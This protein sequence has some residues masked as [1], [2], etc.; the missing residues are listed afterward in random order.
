MS[1]DFRRRNI[2]NPRKFSPQKSLSCCYPQKFNCENVLQLYPRKFSP[3]KINP[4]YGMLYC[5]NFNMK[6]RGVYLAKA[7]FDLF[8]PINVLIA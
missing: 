7:Y 8:M 2:A 5:Q 1:S 4:L 6:T 3:L